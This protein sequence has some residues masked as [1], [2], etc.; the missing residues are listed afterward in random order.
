MKTWRTDELLVGIMWS[1]HNRYE[2]FNEDPSLLDYNNVAIK[3]PVGFVKENWILLN[4]HWD[5][6]CSINYYKNFYD[7][8]GL[9]INTLEHILRV[10]WFLEKHNIRYFMT[11]FAPMT[12]PEKNSLD[13][14][15]LKYLYDMIDWNN[16]LPV[17]SCMEWCVEESNVPGRNDAMHHLSSRH[18]SKEQHEAFTERVIIPHLKNKGLING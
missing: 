12:F 17:K 6:K 9:H 11:S 13:D 3:N 2:I 4:H 1:G 8:I 15:N 14:P 5:D 16:F 18:P 10:Q 7:H